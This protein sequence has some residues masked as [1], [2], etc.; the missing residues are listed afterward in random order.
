M[1]R[2]IHTLVMPLILCVAT[3]AACGAVR[4]PANR[5][6]I[7]PTL[8]TTA[9]QT[10]LVCSGRT[11][12]IGAAE[13]NGMI[14]RC[15]VTAAPASMTSFRL[16]A[17]LPGSASVAA[18]TYPLCTGTLSAGAGVCGQTFIAPSDEWGASLT[19]GGVLL[20]GNLSLPVVTVSTR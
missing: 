15:I 9:T 18:R 20:P 12:P 19:I 13:E 5:T 8:V 14:L 16:S 4:S 6:P 17:T 3:L 11:T 1:R 7:T 2:R 10:R